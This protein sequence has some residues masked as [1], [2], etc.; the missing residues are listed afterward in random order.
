MASEFQTIALVGRT[1]DARVLEP[2]QALA[3]HLRGSGI[4][5]IA[6]AR[7]ASSVAADAVEE[8]AL[9]AAADLFIAIGGDGTILYA[10]DLARDLERPLLGVN[11]GRLGFLA[12]I[13][14]DKMLASVDQILSGE[15]T[16]EPRLLLDARITSDDGTVRSATALN[17]VVLQRRETGRMVD[18]ETRIGGR[19]INTHAGDGLIVATPTGSTAYSLSCG[20]PIMEPGMNSIVLV[21]I[22]PHTL[23][24]RPLVISA[25]HLV[26]VVIVERAGCKGE[27]VVDGRSLGELA[28]TD[29][30]AISAS[31]K[32]IN[33]LHPPGHDYYNILRT[34]L[35]WGRDSRVRHQ[36]DHSSGSQE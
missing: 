17:D 14:P 11:R 19:Y 15:Y 21:P 20:G 34:K 36:S 28:P 5:V 4:T 12:D 27:V 25:D 22:C 8:S 13:S 1:E 16:S 6:D 18:F 2:M 31:D 10:A 24:D 35:N 32:R 9:A 3:E 23:S 30:L 26:E 7:V 29:V 33:L